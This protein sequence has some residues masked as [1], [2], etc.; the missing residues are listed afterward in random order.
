MRPIFSL[1][2]LVVS[3]NQL[4][5]Q[6]NYNANNVV[7]PYDSKFYFGCNTSYYGPA[8]PDEL[9][10]DIA[11]G[12]PV[13]GQDGIGVK[14]LRVA[15]FEH[16]L[17]EW[18]YDIR[19]STFEHYAA[20]GIK[21]L[22][23]FVGYPS[24]AHR[25]HTQ[26][27]NG[28]SSEVFA[29]LYT[30]IWDNGE[31][32]TP[33]NDN[34]YYALYLYKMVN[35]YKDHVKF[36]EVWNEPDF[37]YSGNG[38]KPS[39]LA[40]NWW[41]ADPNPCDVAL[42]ASVQHYIRMLR[43]S[44]EVIKSLDPSAYVTVGGLG[45]ASYYDAI[46]RNTDNPFDGSVTP[47]YPYRGGAYF[48]VLSFHSYPHLDE[49]M[50]KWNN[51]TG[52]FDFFRHSDQ[53]AQGFIDKKDKFLSV[54]QSYGYNNI[55]YPEKLLIS[56]ETNIPSKRFGEYIGS[57][58]A[59]LNY[60]LKTIV[61]S[62]KHD[63]RQLYFYNLGEASSYNFDYETEFNYMGFYNKL[64][65][66]QPYTQEMTASG[67]AMK[68][69]ATLLEG[70]R[71]DPVQTAAL[72]LGSNVDGAVFVKDD[73]AT[74]MLWAKTTADLSETAWVDYSM[75]AQLNLG[76]LEKKN[77]N[78]SVTETFQTISPEHILLN[79]VPIFLRAFSQI[80]PV[81]LI[82]FEAFRKGSA[83]QLYW[84][85]A[86]EE[87]NKKFIIQH[88]SDKLNFRDIGEVD[89]A[90][91]STETNIY[92]FLHKQPLRGTNYYRLRQVD[93]DGTENY[94]HIVSID[95]ET[96]D[97]F[98]VRPNITTDIV[99]LDFYEYFDRDVEAIL[100]N[101]VGQ[102]LEEKVLPPGE[103]SVSFDLSGYKPGHY[104]LRIKV[105]GEGFFTKRLVKVNE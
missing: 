8:W 9:L 35:I 28:Y 43:I 101:L 58:T 57:D 63:V 98:V 62:Y 33:V 77:W 41:D 6:V 31:N 93:F 18:G 76:Q 71:Y 85:T 2:L 74:Y 29:N 82:E 69:I 20:L 36:W 86:N 40:G 7:L 54:S 97:L 42:R 68:T 22:T 92:K 21:D 44:Y 3:F 61:H 83:V 91:N 60:V 12:N 17:E 80:L 67:I 14:T 51:N 32:G 73:I 38:W 64:E 37:D 48:D 5:A 66:L 88:S 46:L 52:T 16:F 90:G 23:V 105:Q 1:F 47:D 59:Q 81:E 10:G 53:A 4:F 89:G 34:N 13:V 49:S 50:R 15:L 55:N 27:C 56:T 96:D 104:F 100:F 30:D 72:N 102:K 25:D 26:Y 19:L 11:A 79:S 87:N 95:I 70:H 65:D 39:G 24:E 75:P 103:N 84:A 78:H 99:N 45:Y 94:T